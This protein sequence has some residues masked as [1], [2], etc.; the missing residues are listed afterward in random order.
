MN[1]HGADPDDNAIAIDEFTWGQI[2]HMLFDGLAQAICSK[3]GHEYTIELDAEEYDCLDG[4]GALGS[5]TS[6]LCK[7]GLI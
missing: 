4:C 7:L 3:F 2:H 5:V 1:H 6:P